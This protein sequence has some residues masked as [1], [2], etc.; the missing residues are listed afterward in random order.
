MKSL[1]V[2]N[3]EVFQDFSVDYRT[4]VGQHFSPD[5]H[6]VKNPLKLAS[7]NCAVNNFK[8]IFSY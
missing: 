4:Y 6:A 7:F 1:N 2:E 5:S 3:W 8:V